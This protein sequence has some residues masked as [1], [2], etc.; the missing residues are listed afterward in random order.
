MMPIRDM[1]ELDQARACAESLI[2]HAPD[3]VFVSDLEGKILQ[4]NDAVLSLLGFRP[5]ELI[6]QSLEES[7]RELRD[8]NQAKDQFLAVV[9][10]KPRTPL[11]AMLGWV[12]LLSAGMLDTSRSSHALEVTERNTKLLAQLIE[13][14]LADAREL[15]TTILGQAGADVIAAA[16]AHE[17]L[18]EVRRWRPDVLVSDIGMPG[19]DGYALIRKIRTLPPDEGGRLQALAL[20]AY[21]RSEDRVRA[22]EAR[23]QTHADG[24][25]RFA[26]SRA[27]G[28]T[29]RHRESAA[30]GKLRED[31]QI[32]VEGNGVARRRT[33]FIRPGCSE[34]R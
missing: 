6:E 8:A 22:L 32:V 13:D 26:G 7:Q 2:K 12:R 25:H 5:D 18:A 24:A 17:A 28:L 23:F 27:A 15:L 19:D 11:T 3:P 4:A 10:H 21:A 34:P 9:S 14:L 16:S 20:T 31:G 33:S 1:R 29:E 30:E